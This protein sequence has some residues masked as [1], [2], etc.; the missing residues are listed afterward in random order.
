MNKHTKKCLLIL[1]YTLQRLRLICLA[2]KSNVSSA[3]LTA[4][5]AEWRASGEEEEGEEEKMEEG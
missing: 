5:R 4:G 3:T 1:L 2:L